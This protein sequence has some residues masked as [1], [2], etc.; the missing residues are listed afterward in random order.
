[1]PGAGKSSV[2]RWLSRLTELRVVYLDEAVAQRF[3][4]NAAQFIRTRGLGAFREAERMVLAELLGSDSPPEVLALG[5]GT[6]TDPEARAMVLGRCRTVYLHCDLEELARRCGRDGG[7]P[8]LEGAESLAEGLRELM[9][10]RKHLY[11]MADWTLDVS[12]LSLM[13][14]VAG[15]AR[16]G[17]VDLVPGDVLISGTGPGWL[18]Q[19]GRVSPVVVSGCGAYEGLWAELGSFVGDTL[20]GRERVLVMDRG[21]PAESRSA[22]G[23]G[24]QARAVLEVAGGEAVKDYEFIREFAGQLMGAGVNRG[25]GVVVA[26]GGATMD[27]VGLACA[28]FMRGVEVVLVPT[29]LLAAVD[30]AIG[31][32][33]AVNC[34]GAKNMLGVVRLPAGVF[35]SMPTLVSAVGGHWSAAGEI[36]KVGILTGDKELAGWAAEL[37]EARCGGAT[38]GG[39]M[40]EGRFE[41]MVRRAIGA[42][43]RFV[44]GDL[45]ERFGRRRMLNLGHTF[46]HALEATKGFGLPHGACVGAGLVVA[47]GVSRLEGMLEPRVEE[48]IVALARRAGFWPVDGLSASDGERLLSLLELDKKAVEGQV[49]WVVL[50][51]WG[52]PR[53]LRLEKKRA[54]NLLNRL[55]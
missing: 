48:E 38:V 47:A 10:E 54:E 49:E 27:A 15:V 14:S 53:P 18:S 33:C 11:E 34:C 24:C 17:E 52:C 5:G 9:H 3:G 36:M 2:A 13:E 29:T 4:L 1:M 25:V 51:G 45:E 39:L 7:R 23:K 22:I 16:I 41:T 8:L 55:L 28:L 42:K 19:G 44:D 30:A 35:V 31:G 6:L 43:L 37:A 26:G 12:R 21:V 32:K 40:A 46:G 20:S 50:E